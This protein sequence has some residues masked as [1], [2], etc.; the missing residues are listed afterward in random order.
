MSNATTMDRLCSMRLSRMAAAYRD[1]DGDPGVAGMSFDE[2]LALMVDAEWDARRGNKRARLLAQARL[3][4][5]DARLSDVRYDPDRRLD[6]SR[7][8]ELAGCTWVGA[9]TNVVLTGA[10]GSGKTW[11]ACALGAAACDCF[12]S[13]RYV[14]MPEML[15]ELAMPRGEE[16]EKAKRRYQRCELLIVDD[17]LLEPLERNQ[18]RELL[19]LVEARYRR[20]SMVICSQY[21]PSAWHARIEEGALADAVVDRLVYSSEMIHIEGDESM[22][23]RIR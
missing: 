11:I 19:E 4:F 9:H 21:R 22:R 1:Q 7:M 5:P 20:G 6:R 10:T 8:A 23:K 12:R 2:R 18:S 3:A 17:W 13:T 14:R 15:D 16:W